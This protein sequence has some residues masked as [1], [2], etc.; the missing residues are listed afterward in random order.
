MKKKHQVVMLPTNKGIIIN[1]N[2]E[3]NGKGHLYITSN[4]RPKKGDYAIYLECATERKPLKGA[5]VYKVEDPEECHWNDLKIIATTDTKLTKGSLHQSAKERLDTKSVYQ[6]TQ[7]FIE[8]WCKRG[9]VGEVEVEYE[10][11]YIPGIDD[12][13]F[14]FATSNTVYKIKVNPD[15][16]INA[17]FIKEEMYSEAFVLWYSGMRLESIQK[18]HKRWIKE[19]P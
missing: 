13:G 8:E 18:A 5:E 2:C 17:S 11:D 6:L 19:N 1:T 10:E 12:N 14:G 9:G 4:E 3:P 16:T 7:S 15:N